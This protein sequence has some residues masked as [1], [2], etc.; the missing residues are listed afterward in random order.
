MKYAIEQLWTD[1][2]AFEIVREVSDKTIE[3][4]PMEQ[5]FKWEN[6]YA[7]KQIWHFISRPDYETF[8]IRLSKKGYWVSKG[9]K[10]FLSDKPQAYYDPSF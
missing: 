6:G 4:R 2:T 3:I 5:D 1:R 9:R 10:F 8:R 7:S